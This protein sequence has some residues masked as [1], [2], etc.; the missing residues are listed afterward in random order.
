MS[1]IGVEEEVIDI[2]SDLRPLINVTWNKTSFIH[3][4]LKPNLS[5]GKNRV[6]TTLADLFQRYLYTRR[7]RI[8]GLSDFDPSPWPTG[9]RMGPQIPKPL[10]LEPS[11]T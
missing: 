5:S 2:E 9:L 11:L 7:F 6:F 10:Y 1:D 3:L 4:N 8:Q